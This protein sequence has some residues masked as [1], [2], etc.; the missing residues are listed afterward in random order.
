MTIKVVLHG[1]YREA[2]PAGYKRGV[3]LH[4]NTVK[5][6]VVAL[7]QLIPLR[8]MIDTMPCEIRTGPTLKNSTSLNGTAV[9]ANWQL[10][11]GT[12]LH[13]APHTTGQEITTAMLVTAIVS[14]VASVAASLLINLLMPATQTT[15]DNRKSALY[16]N[17]VNTQTE[18]SPL[19]YIAGDRV[20][21]G[22]NVVEADVDYTNN[23][24]RQ[25]LGQNVWDAKFGGT[26][27]N[28]LTDAM[29]QQALG[30]K[31]GGK[32]ISN[33]TYSDAVLRITAAIGAGEIG[34]IIGDTPSEKEKNILVN[35]V[36][37]R[38]RGTNALLYN[39]I[40]WAASQSGW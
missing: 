2:L 38:D 15:N 29:L 32:T 18:G 3:T 21:C 11:S 13:I 36:P 17:G 33:T 4:A 25:N 27:A 10:A 23:G 20:F 40:S 24:G 1:A 8:R 30:A 12:V 31:G 14:A 6:A 19:A 39:G 35:E 28:H 9:E 37:L 16:E 22:F 26:G 5:E 7:E 34:G